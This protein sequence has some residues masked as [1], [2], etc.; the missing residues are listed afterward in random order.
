LINILFSLKDSEGSHEDDEDNDRFLEELEQE[1]LMLEKEL[2]S[3]MQ[4]K[5]SQQKENQQPSMLSKEHSP[6]SERANLE[7]IEEKVEEER[8]SYYYSNS[9]DEQSSNK[10]LKQYIEYFYSQQTK[11]KNSNSKR[12]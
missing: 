11:E 9:E 6:I 5:S 2:E 3:L 1:N 12:C 7:R 8:E 4:L 10:K